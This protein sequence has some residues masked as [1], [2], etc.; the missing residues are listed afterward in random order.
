M[1]V[2]SRYL[3]APPPA[4]PV[5]LIAGDRFFVR[6]VPLLPEEPAGP[7]VV[8]AL[9][10]MAPFPPDQ[11]YHGYITTENKASALVFAAYRRRFD[12]AEVEGWGGARFVAPEFL[13]LCSPPPAEVAELIRLHTTENRLTALAWTAGETLPVLVL[14]REGAPD[15]ADAFLDHVRERAGLSPNAGVQHLSG[16]LTASTG[17]TGEPVFTVGE[18]VLPAPSDAWFETAD[19]RDPDF[20]Q[21][22]RRAA[23]RDLWLW[24]SLLASAALLALAAV[25]DLGGGLLRWQTNRRVAQV[26]AQAE[27]VAQIDTAQALANRIAELSEKRLMPF[28][29]L[30]VINPSRPDSI[31][32]RSTKTIGLHGLSIDGQAG[33]AEDIGTY[34]SS[35]RSLPGIAEVKTRGVRSSS[36]G[37]TSFGL[38]LVFKPDALRNGGAL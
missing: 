23:V 33:N 27:L 21:D 36:E 2:L 8:L 5:L 4:P 30:A 22:R 11:L 18:T 34:A 19:V 38:D 3:P 25:I 9:E 28:E 24:R 20:L 29:M 32:F 35:L 17:T 31:V 12:A 16:P 1:S 14:T 10:G 7:Q 6:R 15:A 37:G 26:K 13:A